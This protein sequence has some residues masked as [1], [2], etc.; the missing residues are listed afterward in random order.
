MLSDDETIE[1]SSQPF[2]Y[3]TRFTSNHALFGDKSVARWYQ[4]NLITI[5]KDSIGT[6]LSKIW[7]INTSTL[8]LEE[9]CDERTKIYAIL[10]HR[11]EDEEI[12]FN[13][14]QKPEL[15]AEKRG[16]W[17]IIRLCELALIDEYKYV[18][19]DTCCINKQSS[20]ELT[21]AINSMF[22]WYKAAAICYVF[23][24][25]VDSNTPS[26]GSK[27]QQITDS[28]WFERGWT[29]QELLAP[30]NVAFYD[31]QWSF[32][33]TKQTLRGVLTRRTGIEEAALDGTPLSGYSIAQR[34]SWAAPRKT[35]RTKDI[36]YCLLGLF[37]VNMP[38]LYGEGTRAFLRL[39]E[40]IIKQSDDHTI[41]AWPIGERDQTGLLADS[42][43]S[44]ANCRDVKALTM[45]RGRLPYSM[46][47]RGLSCKLVA[48]PF[49][50]DTYLVRLDCLDYANEAVYR[51]AFGGDHFPQ[52]HMGIFLRRLD[53]DDQYARVEH[54]GNTFIHATAA[55]WNK[56]PS[57]NILA[58]VK[59]QKAKEEKDF[60]EVF[61]YIKAHVSQYNLKPSEEQCVARLNG[62]RI[63]TQKWLQRSS[64]GEPLFSVS[65]SVWDSQKSTMCRR[66]GQHGYMG[67]LD[68]TRQRC[69]IQQLQLG[70][71]FEYNP[72]CFIFGA[73]E[74]RPRTYL[75]DLFNSEKNI[76]HCRRIWFDAH[77]WSEVNANRDAW[78]LE[79]HQGIWALK[80]D[81][82]WGLK[83]RLL[84]RL[85]PR[86]EYI[87]SIEIWRGAMP[88]RF[89]WNARFEN[90]ERPQNEAP[91]E[92]GRL[93]EPGETNWREKSNKSTTPHAHRSKPKL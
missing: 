17:K 26:K 50:T 88:N 87:A 73:T 74:L 33:G 13:E 31:S 60:P 78:D 35:T 61:R 39:Q 5:Y 4:L 15:I 34:M 72:V 55:T 29:L 21:E 9:V 83:A 25:D 76:Q 1:Q 53:E 3:Y 46:T 30:S 27:E 43:A 89:V 16:F 20:A 64:S 51:A 41:F 68:V 48:K 62:F 18:W 69:R 22:R 7:L 44:F 49:V 58:L 56:L 59:S 28:V 8:K 85:E 12:S 19:A 32:L 42:P 66:A 86:S 79:G 90:L 92:S 11:W 24:S 65:D 63:A 45:R 36:A 40:E 23:L 67:T 57:A 71:D 80:G 84:S 6:V 2:P 75:A 70:F 54:Q 77:D 93:A 14:M 38:M 81:R 52:Y 82:L 91:C 10:S 47:N 37:Q